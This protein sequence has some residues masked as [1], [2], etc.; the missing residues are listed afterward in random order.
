MILNGWSGGDAHYA[1][2]GR[3]LTFASRFETVAKTIS[4]YVGLKKNR[5]VVDSDSALRDLT[6]KLRKMPLARHIS[7]LGLDEDSVGTV[8]RAARR[9]RNEIANGLTF[10][11]DRC[12]DTLPK[13]YMEG[14]VEHLESLAISLAEG[15]RIVSYL[16]AV[17]TNEQ[18]LSPKFLNEY[19]TKV[20]AWICEI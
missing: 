12:L 18:L 9:A 14:F 10:G 8:L 6:E 3:L 2:L 4:L 11:L 1:A 5:S 7:D 15:D 19:P 20:A 16:A 17:S 13:E